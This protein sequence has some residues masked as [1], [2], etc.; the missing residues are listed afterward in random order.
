ME[1]KSIQNKALRRLVEDG[2]TKGL[3]EPERLIDMIVYI[4][5]ASSFEELSIPP[6]FGFHALKGDRKG[7]F[8][9]TVTKNWR[10]TFSKIDSQTIGDLNLE[11]YH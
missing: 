7:D 2:K 10:L 1:I 5:A 3:I 6:N 11:D 4:D 8:A 9:M